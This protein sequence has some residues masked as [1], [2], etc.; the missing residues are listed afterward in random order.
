[1]VFFCATF[2]SVVPDA[3]ILIFSKTFTQFDFLVKVDLRGG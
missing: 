1:M 2:D 3:K